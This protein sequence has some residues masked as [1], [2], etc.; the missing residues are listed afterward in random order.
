MNNGRSGFP[1]PAYGKPEQKR[2]YPAY[3]S[4]NET[5]CSNGTNLYKTAK[6]GGQQQQ[7][8]GKDNYSN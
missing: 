8:K 2:Y 5:G 1:S 4:C 7:N 3:T 6:Q